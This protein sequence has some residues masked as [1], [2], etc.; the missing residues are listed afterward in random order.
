MR[1]FLIAGNWKMNLTGAESSRLARELAAQLPAGCPAETAII[2]SLVHLQAVRREIADTPIKLGAQ[3]VYWEKK[4]AFTGEVSAAMLKEIGVAFVL[5]GHSER[6]HIIGETDALLNKKT[7]AVID[8]GLTVI[9]CVGE[10]LEERQGN[11]TMEVI[12]RQINASLAGVAPQAVAKEQVVIAYE[13]VWAI[14]TGLTATPRQAQEVHAF[15]RARLGELYGLQAAA[16]IRIQYGGSVKKTNAAELL[17]QPDI[18]GLLVGG[19]SLAADE[20]IGIVQAA[21]T[22]KTDRAVAIG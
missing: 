5:V 8:E 18:D 21:R 3:N 2:P 19:A 10:R 14:G 15:I 7:C 13:P 1:K 9:L 20:F 16:T 6:R 11:Q 22:A 17:S 12:G 4:G